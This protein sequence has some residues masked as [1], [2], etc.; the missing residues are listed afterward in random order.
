MATF[1]SITTSP[2]EEARAQAR[3]RAPQRIRRPLRGIQV[4]EDTYAAIRVKK[5]NGEDIPL[6]DSGSADYGDDNIGRSSMNSNFL[7]ASVDE[8]RAEKQQIVETFGEDYI[9]F[10]GERPRFLRFTGA[11]INTADFNW[12]SE[13]MENY[14]QHLRGTRLVE[15]NARAYIYFDDVVVEG[16]I[17][18]SA[19][20]WRTESPYMV[21]FNFTLFVSNYAHLSNVGSVFRPL[22]VEPEFDFTNDPS[23][24]PDAEQRSTFTGHA[25]KPAVVAG[26]GAYLAEQAAFQ[27]VADFSIQNTLETI[28]NTF[29]GRQLVIP[30]GLGNQVTVP[31]I[32]NQANFPVAERTNQPIFKQNDEFIGEDSV[33]DPEYDT[34]ELKRVQEELR[35]RSPE[36][37]ERRARKEL[38]L[39]GIDVTRRETNYLLLGRGAFAATQYMASFGLR[40][41]DGQLGQAFRS[42]GFQFP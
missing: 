31:P 29:Y 41:A 22:W 39:L 33:T 26:L 42:T 28:R 30:N 40:R 5:S 13:F 8:Q 17:V 6:L 7:L 12:K 37:L 24:M 20:G 15:Q 1:I 25:V 35:L 9:F 2:F 34:A 4:K 36:E 38:E 32:T 11:L 19:V 16:Y 14:E 3:Q 23:V 27:T 18:D 21:N 10:F